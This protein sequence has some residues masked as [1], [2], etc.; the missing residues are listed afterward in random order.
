MR[1]VMLVVFTDE[2]GD[3]PQNVDEAI[4]LC[5]RYEMPVYVV[6][7]PAPFGR[8]EAYVKYV[9]PDSRFDQS[10]QWVPVHQGPESLLPERIKLHLYGQRDDRSPI[11]SG[12]G[13]F[14]LTRLCYETGGIYFA[15]HP[16]HQLERAV[17]A[18]EVDELASHLKYFFDPEVMRRYRPD[19]IS[20]QAYEDVIR[21]NKARAA[22]VQAARLS[23]VTPMES[24]RLDF[25]KPSE[26]E[27]VN[28]LSRAQQES[29]RLE[30]KIGRIYA[31]LAEGEADRDRL[32]GPR[33]QA[34]YDLA[35]GRTLAVKVRTES[36]NAML[37]LAKGTMQFKEDRSDT[38]VLRPA[39]TITVGSTL[40]KQGQRAREYLE[41]VVREH[42]DTPWAMLAKEELAQPL[43]WRWTER[44]A[45]LDRQRE[46]QAANNA[47]RMQGRPD[48]QARMLPRPKP[49]RPL[50]AL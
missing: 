3:D 27:L 11:A 45:G 47:M 40:E 29:A 30:P 35:M 21:E 18:G 6:G 8:S 13:P 19:Y 1:N 9:D 50:P 15:V 7:V 44:Y 24:I 14:H 32:T 2:A 36:Y 4:R 5:G 22:L 46:Q 10:P 42:A 39:D 26:A 16:Q 17:R 37:A 31:V 34:G 49:R 33:W 25:P 28:A 43:G 38:W 48:E 41:R 23:W 12:F 20:S